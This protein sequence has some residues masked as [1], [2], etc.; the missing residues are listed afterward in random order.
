MGLIWSGETQLHWRNSNSLDIFNCKGEIIQF[1]NSLGFDKIRFKECENQG[2]DMCLKIFYNKVQ[3]GFLGYLNDELKKK[4][5]IKSKLVIC[6]LSIMDLRNIKKNDKFIFKVP[7]QYPSINR[8]I[9]LQVKKNI[10][11]ENL[12]DVIKKEGGD[13]LKEISL[14]DIY[15]SKDVGDNNRS[16]AFSLQFQSNNSTLTDIEID[17]IISKILKSLSDCYGAIQR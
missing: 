8:D 16:L 1:L 10:S 12:F 13:L 4:Y 14:F 7:S 5:E 6:D 17:P 15:E 3:L 9:A 11:A 2:Y